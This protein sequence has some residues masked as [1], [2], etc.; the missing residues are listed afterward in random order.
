MQNYT[1][2]S[3]ASTPGRTNRAIA[4]AVPDDADR[5]DENV[6]PT[7]VELRREKTQEEIRLAAAGYDHLTKDK[8]SPEDTKFGDVDVTEHSLPIHEVE[9][10]PHP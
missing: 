4:V 10:L 9:S 3:R 7:G 8:P 6:R 2:R 5:H 1:R